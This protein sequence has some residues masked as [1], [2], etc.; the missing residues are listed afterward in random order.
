R[1]DPSAF[2]RFIQLRNLAER[3][4]LGET[5]RREVFRGAGEQCEKRAAG[6]MRTAGAPIEPRGDVGSSQRLLEQTEIALRRSDEDG[7]LVESDAAARF[8]Q[9]APRDLDAL[10]TFAGCGKEFQ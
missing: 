1:H 9:D 2:V 10:A 3:Q 4:V 7:H 5:R 6:W 8:F